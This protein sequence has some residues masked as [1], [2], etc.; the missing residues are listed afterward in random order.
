MLKLNSSTKF[1]KDLKLCAKRHYDL[2]LLKEIVNTLRIPAPLPAKNKDHGLS[3]N[4]IKER[5]CHIEP[6]WILIY[7]IEGDELYLIRTGTHSDLLNM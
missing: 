4:H 7:R 5:E 6:D 1:K 2:E 3:G